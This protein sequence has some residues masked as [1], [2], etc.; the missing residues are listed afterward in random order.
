MSPSLATL[1]RLLGDLL[2]LLHHRRAARFPTERLLCFADT[3]CAAFPELLTRVADFVRL[4][5][6]TTAITS[7]ISFGRFFRGHRFFRER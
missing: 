6:H 7:Y 1:V 2:R 4:R 3:R 5:R